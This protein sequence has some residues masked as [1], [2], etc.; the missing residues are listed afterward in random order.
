MT[1]EQKQESPPDQATTY[2]LSK[3]KKRNKKQQ[4]AWLV[5]AIEGE[6]VPAQ[7][8][9]KKISEGKPTTASCHSEE[10][11]KSV[12]CFHMQIISWLMTLPRTLFSLQPAV[13]LVT[14]HIIPQDL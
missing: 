14:H 6:E 9:H 13:R 3:Q 5:Q 11:K 12:G 8:I 10:E 4:A 1:Y 7:H 2:P